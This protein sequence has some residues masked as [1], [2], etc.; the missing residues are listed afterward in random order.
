MNSSKHLAKT[1]AIVA[2]TIAM[3][4]FAPAALAAPVG[5]TAVYNLDISQPAS[6]LPDT[7]YGTVTLTQQMDAVDV[8][9][10][11]A[12][13][14]LFANTGVGAQFAFNLSP[15]FDNA[16]ISL[17]AA[18]AAN[19]ELGTN[20]PYNMTPYGYFTDV[21]MFKSG[22]GSGL[23]GNIGTPLNFTVSQAGISLDA[24][25]LSGP[26]SSGQPGGYSFAAD[27][28]YAASG[29]TGGVAAIGFVATEP[30]PTKVPEPASLALLG[31]GL[32]GAVLARRRR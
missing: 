7:T 14:F 12:S 22:I 18:T 1:A 31:L 23:S 26:R 5:T 20:S 16:A 17:A 11:L 27:V 19:F 32:A 28:G 2:G 24:F 15:A 4:S 25:V 3:F 9:V 30:P 6:G 13:G 10:T 21:L 8:N 29:N